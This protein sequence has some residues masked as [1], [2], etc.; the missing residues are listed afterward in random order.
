MTTTGHWMADGEKPPTKTMLG[1]KLLLLLDGFFLDPF[2][3][4]SI[5]ALGIQ[6]ARISLF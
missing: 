3:I 4:I 2:V 6:L 1:V 5:C